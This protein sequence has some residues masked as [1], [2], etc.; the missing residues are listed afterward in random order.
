MAGLFN[1]DSKADELKYWLEAIEN[2]KT[3]Y[4]GLGVEVFPD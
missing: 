4:V 3:R 2:A 1:P